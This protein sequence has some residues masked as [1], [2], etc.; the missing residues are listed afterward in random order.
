[1]WNRE[2]QERIEKSNKRYAK[3]IGSLDVQTR[4]A[5][6]QDFVSDLHSESASKNIITCSN[7]VRNIR[8]NRTYALPYVH[9]INRL[10]QKYGYKK[11]IW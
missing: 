7:T 5:F 8:Y 1:M 3:F 10:A 6:E 11:K 9:I 2:T 4:L